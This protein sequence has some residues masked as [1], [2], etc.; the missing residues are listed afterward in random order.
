MFNY[1]YANC[2]P[3]LVAQYY[4]LN[5]TPKATD[6]EDVVYHL[7]ASVHSN[8]VY[9]RCCHRHPTELPEEDRMTISEQ[10]VNCPEMRQW[11]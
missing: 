10:V 8:S 3:E 1:W 9:T 2:H 6:L 7:T 5:N 4:N 11:K